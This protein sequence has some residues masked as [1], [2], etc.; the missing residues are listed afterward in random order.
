MDKNV[1][2]PANHVIIIDDDHLVRD[3]AVHT[4]EY[5]VNRK[6]IAFDSGFHAWKFFQHYPHM[7][8]VVIADVNIPEM[9]GIELLTEFKQKY[10][11]KIFVITTSNASYETLAGRLGADAFLLKPFDINELFFVV[12][13]FIM[14]SGDMDIENVTPSPTTLKSQPDQPS[15]Q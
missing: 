15:L 10:P 6:V 7:V 13:R 12:K 14:G 3:F 5:G 9:D 8:D 11:D 2:S 4:I 1:Q